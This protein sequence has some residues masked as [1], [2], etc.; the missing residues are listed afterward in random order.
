MPSESRRKSRD[1]HAPP[2]DFDHESAFDFKDVEEEYKKIDARFTERLRT[3]KAGGGRFNP[4]QLGNL[5]IQPDKK[6][7]ATYPLRE[8]ATVVQ[9]GGRTVSILAS[10]VSYVKPIMS[11]VLKSSEFNQQPQR[12]EDNELE[13]LLRIEAENPEELAKRLKA[14]CNSWRDAI[15]E[16]FSTRK[17]KHAAWGKAKHVTKDDV[18]TLDNKVK[19]LQDKKMD[20]ITKAEKQAQTELANRQQ[21][22]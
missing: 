4:D 20:E 17:S 22:L 10:D 19:A 2:S 1:R 13:L 11:A 15:R 12:D 14:E 6:D 21:R 3:F 8:L 9:K 7:Q 5:R 18:K 16:V